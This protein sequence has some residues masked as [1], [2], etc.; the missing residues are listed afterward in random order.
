ML[1]RR[2]IQPTADLKEILKLIRKTITKRGHKMVDYDRFRV[3]LKKLKDKKERNLNDEKQ[4]FKV[5]DWMNEGRDG[6]E[7]SG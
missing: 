6:V 2:V 1:D 4:I 3:N 7:M 5:C